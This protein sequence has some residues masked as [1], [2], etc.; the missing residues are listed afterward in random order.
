MDAATHMLDRTV[1][2]VEAAG[3]TA[4]RTVTLGDPVDQIVR[5]AETESIGL[6]VMS[7]HGRSGI[8][9]WVIGSVADAVVRRTAV[10]SLLVRPQ[11]TGHD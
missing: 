9:R 1:T 10:P 5:L 3:L 6:I 11:L 7:T 8:G 2:E 4:S